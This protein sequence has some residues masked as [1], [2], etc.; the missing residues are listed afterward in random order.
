MHDGGG[1]GIIYRSGYN[2]GLE[3]AVETVRRLDAER[4][5]TLV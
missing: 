1:E 5:K 2:A 4:V 3:F